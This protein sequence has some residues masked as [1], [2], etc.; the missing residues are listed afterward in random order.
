MITAPSWKKYEEGMHDNNPKKALDSGRSFELERKY[1]ME[2]SK[3]TEDWEKGRKKAWDKAKPGWVKKQ[4]NKE[5]EIA[6]NELSKF[7]RGGKYEYNL[8]PSRGLILV[9]IIKEEQP[10]TE[11]GLILSS[12]TDIPNE[13][14]D[15][16]AAGMDLIH[17]K[18]IEPSPCN[19][20]DRILLKKM[21]GLDVEVKGEMLK[22]VLFS[23]VL[24][25]LEE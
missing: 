23:D 5:K 22:L 14:A 7:K 18:N 24:A 21:A 6:L 4:N 1:Q 25:L 20:G 8:L 11:S 3:N 2:L 16:L 12:D 9:K 15:V 13:T 17:E 19:P 10:K